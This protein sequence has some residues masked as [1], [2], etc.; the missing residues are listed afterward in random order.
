MNYQE[1][2]IEF[3]NFYS[4][5]EGFLRSAEG[6]FRSLCESILADAKFLTHHVSSRVK[7]RESSLDKFDKRYRTQ[8]ETEGITY[9]IKEKISDLIGI[10]VICFYEQDVIDIADLLEKTL[11]P[12]SPRKD[13]FAERDTTPNEFGYRAIH[14]NLGLNEDRMNLAEYRRFSNL[15]FE[16]QIRTVIQDAWSVL[17]HKLQYKGHASSKLKRSINAL[18]AVFEQADQN[19]ASIR[20]Q[21]DAEQDEARKKVE[22]A[23]VV[24]VPVIPDGF[25]AARAAPVRPTEPVDVISLN[26]LMKNFFPDFNGSL[27][28]SARL[29]D[30]IG[31]AARELTLDDIKDR[32]NKS[33]PQINEYET[34]SE[35]IAKLS[36]LTKLRHGL[37][38]SDNNKFKTALFDY[39]RTNF[40]RWIAD[41]VGPGPAKEVAMH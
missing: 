37:Y 32:L 7:S 9:H 17:D 30:D 31:E 6:F 35:R 23:T 40:D 28:S 15:S 14:L 25:A 10:R 16:V 22:A 41:K 39:Q 5:N 3:H 38:A 2:K 20:A 27:S 19:F 11:K 8:I 24:T 4:A 1:A 26:E 34:E 33:I 12:Q 21:V 13:R 36:P 29:L 18:A